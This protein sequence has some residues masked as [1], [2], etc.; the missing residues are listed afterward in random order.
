M[1]PPPISASSSVRSTRPSRKQRRWRALEPLP[2]PA[3]R[4]TEAGAFPPPEC[5]APDSKLVIPLAH[6]RDNSARDRKYDSEKLAYAACVKGWIALA[7]AEVQQ[8]DSDAHAEM[9]PV[10]DD[11]NR[12]IR[13]IKTT[14]VAAIEETKTVALEQATALNDLKTSLAAVPPP[15]AGPG[16]S[17]SVVV[18]DTHLLPRQ[19]DEPTGVGDPDAIVCRSRQQRPDS[20]IWGP[21]ICKRNRE[22]ADLNK[23]GVQLSSDGLTE[24][25]L[26]KER[27]CHP[28]TCI[29]SHSVTG[30]P[31]STTVC[32]GGL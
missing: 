32:Q 18:T 17:E 31:T 21:E 20:R 19:A 26:E 22:W 15:P 29:T 12:Q 23:R 5:P 7:K 25:D 4:L 28:Q 3:Y 9:K 13:E 16:A 8:I 6:T 30:L 24:I 10:V 1:V 11:A 2:A 27:T 14:I